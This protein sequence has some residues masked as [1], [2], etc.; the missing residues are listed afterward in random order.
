MGFPREIMLGAIPQ[1][2][3]DEEDLTQAVEAAVDIQD[4][5]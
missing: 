2:K 5:V 1:I 3:V 4:M